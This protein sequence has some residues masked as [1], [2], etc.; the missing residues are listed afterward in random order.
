MVLYS[1][2]ES[3]FVL[4][5]HHFYDPHY[6]GADGFHSNKYDVIHKGDQLR[7][8]EIEDNLTRLAPV[9][10]RMIKQSELVVKLPIVHFSQ[11]RHEFARFKARLASIA[12]AFGGNDH[13][14]QT[15]HIRFLRGFKLD[16]DA[17]PH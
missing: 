16:W 9:Y 1:E 10:L 17:G 8:G 2:K 12:D 14:L 7:L 6:Y 4:A 3:Q 5:D 15:L 13:S 11:Y